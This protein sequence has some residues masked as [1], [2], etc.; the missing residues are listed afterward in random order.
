M[1]TR[2]T[3]HDRRPRPAAS[4]RGAAAVGC[5]DIE[6]EITDRQKVLAIDP[7]WLAGVVKRSLAAAG[8]ERATIGVLLVDDTGI[9]KLH[10]R[11]SG[12]PGPTDVLTFDLAA[13]PDAGLMH[14]DIAVSTETAH[15]MARALG[16]QPRHEVAYYVVH[17]L[18][19]LAGEDDHDPVARRRMRARERSLMAAAGLPRPP[20][21]RRSAR[22]ARESR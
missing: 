5:T 12:L 17:G 8:I 13:V 11:F 7:R 2:S 18:L 10:E 9:A 20:A 16:W 1:R 4:P 19:H 15:R 3:A 21:S 6:V 14:G 22:P